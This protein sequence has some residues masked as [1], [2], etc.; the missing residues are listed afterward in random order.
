MKL[1]ILYR[2][3]LSSCNYACGYCPFAKRRES[4]ADLRGDRAAL[5]RFVAWAAEQPHDIGVLF[6]PWGE[7][8]IRRWYQDA[9]VELTQLPH[10]WRAAI[11]TN[12]SCKLDWLPRCRT[13]K[14]GLWTTYHPGEVPMERFVANVLMARRLG[15]RLSVGVVGLK[16][17]LPAIERLRGL[18]PGDI[19]VWINAYKRTPDYYTEREVDFLTAVDPLFPINNRRH[20][21]R[22]A[23][24]AAGETVFTVDGA[25]D[26]RRCHFLPEVLGNIYEGDWLAALQPRPCA[27]ATCGCHLGYVHL[28][29]L[30][31]GRL[32]G[33]GILERAPQHWP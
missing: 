9:L 7:A 3:P 19:Y 6:T 10:V 15:V 23:A 4:F 25:G 2:G 13:A 20:A 8:L 16:E 12:L 1:A 22:G 26:L 32:F 18:L 17:H 14:L 30:G 27:R 28:E 29:R 24:C 11:Q 5:R 33:D 31:L 21:S